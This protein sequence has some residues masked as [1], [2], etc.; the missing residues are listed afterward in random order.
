MRFSREITQSDMIST[1]DIVFDLM[2]FFFNFR[3]YSMP[4]CKSLFFKP[5]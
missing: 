3:S 5:G 1:N 2:V 4:M